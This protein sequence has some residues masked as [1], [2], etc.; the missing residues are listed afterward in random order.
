MDRTEPLM[1]C[2]MCGNVGVR[3]SH[4]WAHYPPSRHPT[5]TVHCLGRM[6]ESVDDA[7]EWANRWA[8]GSI[9]EA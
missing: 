3:T 5:M 1:S 4:G 6:F 7:K 8:G 9:E 2:P